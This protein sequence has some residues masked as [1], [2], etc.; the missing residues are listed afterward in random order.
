MKIMKIDPAPQKDNLIIHKG[1]YSA[2]KY[3]EI[4]VNL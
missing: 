2:I 1:A 4:L 3:L